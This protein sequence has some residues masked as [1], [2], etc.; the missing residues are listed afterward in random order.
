V[1]RAEAR[2]RRYDEADAAVREGLS[3]SAASKNASRD[4]QLRAELGRM[5]EQGV[6]TE[7]AAAAFREARSIR[8][9]AS[10]DG[11]ATAAAAAPPA[12]RARSLGR[13]LSDA[14][15]ELEAAA[16]R[17]ESLAPRS[18]ARANVLRAY[19]WALD[20]RVAAREAF[21]QSLA[22]AEELSP[23]SLVVARAL[24]GLANAIDE[25][26]RQL[27][28]RLRSVDILERVQPDATELVSAYSVLG[29]TL[30]EL[31]DLA[32]G[33]AW[34]ERALALVERLA[35]DTE[36]HAMTLYNTAILHQSA[37]DL[38]GAETLLRR[39]LAIV[40][41]VMPPGERHALVQY[42][43]GLLLLDR[44]ET[45]EAERMLQNALENIAP[46]GRSAA[47][48]GYCFKSL[49]A[50][51]R[52]RNDPEAAER[53]LGEA[54]SVF[55]AVALPTEIANVY[56]ELGRIQASRGKVEEASAAYDQGFAALASHLRTPNLVALH[57]SAGD[58]ALERGD[59]ETAERHHRAALELAEDVAPGSLREA[60]AAH[61]LGTIDRRRGRPAEARAL[62]ERAVAASE[63]QNARLGGSAEVRTRIRAAAP[64]AAALRDPAPLGMAGIR[65]AIDPGT[66]ILS[67]R[68]GPETSRV[69]AVGPGPE[70]F[71]VLPIAAGEK[72]IRQEVERF[73]ERIERRRGTLLRRDLDEQAARLGR[74]LLGPAA[75]RLARAQRLL[76]VPDGVMHLLP[77]AALR[78]P[79]PTGRG[80]YLVEI[81][82]MHVVS[83]LTL[84]A[85]VTRP[86][87]EGGG[88]GT[89][90]V[91]FGDPV[92]PPRAGLPRR[93][94]MTRALGAGLELS[95][96]PASRRELEALKRHF[97][98][99]TD[100][101]VGAEATEERARSVG[102]NTR[103]V[104][105][106][107]HGFADEAFPLE[108][109][110][111][112]S[113]PPDGEDDRENGLLQAWEIFERVRVD[114]DL[115]TLSACRT[116]LGKE[117]AGEGLLGLTWAFQYAG[118]RSVLASLW[119]VNDASTA[120]LM[121]RFY[122]HLQA[123]RSKAEALRRA[124]L[125]LL[126]HPA[127]SPPYLWAA[128]SLTGDWR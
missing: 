118:A 120:E 115:V 111:V 88:P 99:S 54:L 89:A 49:G 15:S 44:G 125:E 116:G 41:R 76:V 32:G 16:A 107:T 14:R 51:A 86:R 70:D 37:G 72:T 83:S 102:R 35:P 6:R 106:A 114:A 34:N 66:L 45:A 98:L 71:A 96:L 58:L 20:S 121:R 7:Q 101:F 68:L 67:Y 12:L 59:L 104:H 26:E 81:L 60:L 4:A 8:V 57:E 30:R 91:G 55:R 73:R 61:A 17:L 28:M 40:E 123:G 80:R 109:G 23:D 52:G 48:R 1:A 103:V 113:I 92:Y 90:V 3:R 64:R 82:P 21:G 69:F 75:P 74:I 127:T 122:G 97:P 46:S 42:A 110:L 95:P 39:T 43:I 19:G 77:F 119:E 18:L 79:S 53:F 84:Y 22:L 62:F 56:S 29:G 50:L 2:H 31:G 13:N 78:D 36:W 108:S 126:R 10:P 27:E 112:L 63:I 100:I 65:Q 9:G 11:V 47:L 25:P 93:P 33:R 124:Q 105:F 24:Y 5:L 85:Q 128:F 38:A 87:Q 117:V 94:A